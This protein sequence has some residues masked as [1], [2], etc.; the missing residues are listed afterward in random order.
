FRQTRQ[1][2]RHPSVPRLCR[3]TLSDFN[4][5]ADANRLRPLVEHSVAA[6]PAAPAGPGQPAD[7]PAE[8]QRVLAVD[9]TSF[10]AAADVAWAVLHR[11]NR[12]RRRAGVR[13]DVHLDVRR[14]P[15][16][17]IAVG[18]AGESEP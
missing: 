7:L 4:R 3:S 1:A 15:P 16:E 11:T 9:G 5:A 6:A 14:W 13:L 12:G 17:V 18:G 10:G 2:Q 8:L